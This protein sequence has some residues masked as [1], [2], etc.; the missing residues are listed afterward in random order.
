MFV[1]CLTPKHWSKGF[2]YI[3]IFIPQNNSVIH[4]IPILK[5]RKPRAMEVKYL[6][7]IAE[8]ILVHF[9][10]PLFPHL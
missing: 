6:P 9:S 2:T 8:Q 3:M 5:M 10:E 7:K 1:E 4:I